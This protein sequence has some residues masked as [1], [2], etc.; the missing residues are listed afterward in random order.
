MF[1]TRR[2]TVCWLITSSTAMSLI[3]F[4]GGNQAEHL[5]FARSE[6]AGQSITLAKES[7]RHVSFRRGSQAL[8][9]R[10]GRA[11]LEPGI[12]FVAGRPKGDPEPDPGAGSF[13]G[14]LELLPD[15]AGAP[16]ALESPGH[17]TLSQAIRST[18][19]RRDRVQG[20]RREVARD[21]TELIA[22]RPGDIE[23]LH[24]ECD[25]DEPRQEAHAAQRAPPLRL[26][27]EAEG[28]QGR[29]SFPLIEPQEGKPGLGLEP[30]FI[31][32]GEGLFGSREPA[33][34]PK[35][36]TSLVEAPRGGDLVVG[37]L[38]GDSPCFGLGLSPR[39]S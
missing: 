29:L 21:R 1:W 24:R 4:A 5:G 10:D 39:S 35:D 20:R 11:H 15:R 31:R 3:R 27:R 7:G 25:V 22:G 30:E 13:I 12:L 33:G 32:V 23:V 8:E 36:L 2:A 19:R 17:V 16:Q 6:P 34:A 14:E 37:L 28:G 26:H 9:R 38:L 18:R